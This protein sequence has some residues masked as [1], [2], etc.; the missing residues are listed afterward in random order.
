LQL[1]SIQGL[2]WFCLRALCGCPNRCS[3]FVGDTAS[4]GLLRPNS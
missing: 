4:I 1:D 2:K 3:G